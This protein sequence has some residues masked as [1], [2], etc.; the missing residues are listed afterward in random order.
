M[1]ARGF[2]EH[3][4]GHDLLEVAIIMNRSEA[5]VNDRLRR[6]FGKPDLTKRARAVSRAMTLRVLQ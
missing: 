3:G 6:M 5:T 1:T 2:E 4:S